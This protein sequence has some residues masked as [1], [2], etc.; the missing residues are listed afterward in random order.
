NWY[1]HM[2][3][4]LLYNFFEHEVIRMFLIAVLV[5]CSVS[6]WINIVSMFTFTIVYKMGVNLTQTTI[7]VLHIYLRNLSNF[8]PSKGNELT[9]K[10]VDIGS[11]VII[12]VMLLG[13]FLSTSSVLAHF[14]AQPHIASF[15]LQQHNTLTEAGI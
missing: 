2:F 7:C 6:E 4:L 8:F 12:I 14:V 9:Q 11:K 5:M 13:A 15:C 3:I 1:A 10:S